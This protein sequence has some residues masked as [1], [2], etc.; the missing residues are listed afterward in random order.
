MAIVAKE[1]IRRRQQAD[2]SKINTDNNYTHVN[3]IKM[4]N[5][6]IFLRDLVAIN[7]DY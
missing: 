2:C 5:V 6:T 4:T 1:Q 3:N 7:M